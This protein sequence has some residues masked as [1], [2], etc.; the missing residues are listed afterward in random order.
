MTLSLDTF[1]NARVSRPTWPRWDFSRRLSRLFHLWAGA[2]C[3]CVLPAH[4]ADPPQ[5]WAHYVRIA[6]HGLR[7][8][9][10]AAIVKESESSNVF[11]IEV[12]NDIP[13]RYESFLDPAA[14]L[15]AIRKAA[16]A[17]HRAGNKAFV[18]I[19]GLEC[20]TA[21]AA[22]TP[23]SFFKDHPDW[24]PAETRWHSRNLRWWNSF[25][26]QARR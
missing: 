6:G 22:N 18:Y 20:I 19:A 24:G 16:D 12:D 8:D 3:L 2:F 26:D 11:G 4:A 23:Y 7:A 21:N 9:N 14:K 5:S 1:A 15:E 13:G 17:V 25:L 10:A